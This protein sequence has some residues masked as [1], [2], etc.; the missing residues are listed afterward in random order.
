MDRFRF[1]TFEELSGPRDDGR[2]LFHALRR[3]VVREVL[4]E[5][6]H[7]RRQVVEVRAFVGAVV[8]LDEGVFALDRYIARN[9]LCC[10]DGTVQGTRIDFVEDDAGVA[11]RIAHALRLFPAHFVQ[12]VVAPPLQDTSLIQFGLPVA[13]DV[14]HKLLLTQQE[15]GNIRVPA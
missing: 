11:E 15:I 10:L 9:E 2:Q 12:R 14:D 5:L 13:D 1:Q 6:L 8:H 3:G 4:E 7:L